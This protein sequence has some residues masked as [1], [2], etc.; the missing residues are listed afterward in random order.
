[1]LTKEKLRR[2]GSI[3]EDQCTY[4]ILQSCSGRSDRITCFLNAFGKRCSIS[5]EVRNL[6]WRAI[7]ETTGTGFKA[8]IRSLTLAATVCVLI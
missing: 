1:M 3:H 5:R 2:W 6:P 4:V 7:A 8:K